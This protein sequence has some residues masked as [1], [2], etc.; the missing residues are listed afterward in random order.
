MATAEETVTVSEKAN[1]SEFL[2]FGGCATKAPPGPPA[3]AHAAAK[4]TSL[5]ALFLSLSLARSPPHTRR[6]LPVPQPP[7][8]TP[9]KKELAYR[10][11]VVAEKRCAPLI[12]AYNA[13]ARGRTVSMLWACRAAYAA[14]QDCVREYVNKPNIEEMR[15]RW[16]AMGRPRWPEWA[17]LLRGLVPDEDLPPPTQKAGG[18]GER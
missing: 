3:H 5:G 10:L 15:R 12:E 11:G 9:P 8:T 17:D 13:C 1:D 4:K 2:G 6:P 18:E 16:V 14:S 7:T